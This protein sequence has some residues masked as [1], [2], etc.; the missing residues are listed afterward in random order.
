MLGQHP[1]SALLNHDI[2]PIVLSNTAFI[3]ALDLPTFTRL[4]RTSQQAR[5]ILHRPRTWYSVLV[6]L[7]G[8]PSGFFKDVHPA[9]NVLVVLRGL[10]CYCSRP[11][12]LYPRSLAIHQIEFGLWWG[13]CRCKVLWL[14]VLRYC[15]GRNKLWPGSH[16]Q[17]WLIWQKRVYPSSMSDQERFQLLDSARIL[18]ARS[19]TASSR[20]VI[21]RFRQHPL[22]YNHQFFRLLP[23]ELF[24]LVTLGK[25]NLCL[26]DCTFASLSGWPAELPQVERLR[27]FNSGSF[28]QYWDWTCIPS[29]PS[30]REFSPP[31][32]LESLDGIEAALPPLHR[33]DLSDCWRLKSLAGL[34]T[35]ANW[36]TLIL[37]P[38]LESLVELG[39]FTNSFNVIDMSSC[40]HIT[41]FASWPS[42]LP[43][44][45]GLVVPSSLE[46]LEGMPESMDLIF[47]DMD[48]GKL[49]SLKG[50]SQNLP[51]LRM[52]STPWR[53]TSLQ[54][55][56]ATLDSLENLNLK[57][58]VHLKNLV[59]LPEA[60]PELRRLELSA[61][62]ESLQGMTVYLPSLLDLNMSKC[63]MLKTVAGL[64]QDFP[65][66]LALALPPSLVSLQALDTA[67]FPS[68]QRLML[69]Q[70][71]VKT[72]D[73]AAWLARTTESCPG[74]EV[75]LYSE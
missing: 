57:A 46:S 12:P 2:L 75:A 24:Q 67:V 58:S 15:H 26:Y 25:R 74:L 70:S 14:R 64:P 29:M 36:S 1:E 21:I 63:K 65:A 20:V 43:Q 28:T 40:Q 37:P 55:L 71:L 31:Q 59:G 22:F 48:T 8:L 42:T 51:N 10:Y 35:M 49:T 38:S 16:D 47:L 5:A 27:V 17:E 34:S 18:Q 41:T 44:L 53:L 30:L 13:L 23:H 3:G 19:Q 54:G 9:V 11:D 33:L 62:L 56:P 73:G 61:N 4:L 32:S 52:L 39:Q 45:G 50:M 60:L 7:L 66:L 68:L 72:V 6:R 69:S